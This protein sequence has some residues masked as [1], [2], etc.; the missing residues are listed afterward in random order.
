M[1]PL[2]LVFVYLTPSSLVDI[3]KALQLTLEDLGLYYEGQVA[4]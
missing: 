2:R 3:T 4:L 1:G